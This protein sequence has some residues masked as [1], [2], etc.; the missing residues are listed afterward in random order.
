MFTSAA[1]ICESAARPAH[2]ALSQT[3]YSVEDDLRRSDLSALVGI[4]GIIYALYFVFTH[5][6]TGFNG[7]WDV[8]AAVLIG[9]TPPCIMLLS[10]T[11]VDLFRGFAIFV[12]SAFNRVNKTQ[13]EVIEVLTRCSALVRTEG[14]GALSRERNGIRYEL[15][16]DGLS[17]ILNDFSADEIRHNI[18]AKIHS[19]QAKMGTASHLFEN[20]SKACPAVGMIG[21]LIGLIT[22]LANLKDPASIGGGMAI[23][24]VTTLYGLMLG[25]I[26]YAPFGE[27]IAIES[28]KVLALDQ[29]ILE[30]ILLLKNKKSSLHLKD[31]VKTYG[32]NKPQAS[33]RDA[34]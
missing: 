10:H 14:I 4:G 17:L 24:M 23:A 7:F 19:K 1:F 32:H 5:P 2:R 8:T 30:G 33:E 27:K 11:L 21:T 9:V 16:R 26:I 6:H 28:E 20:M 18:Q 29:M 22:M 25:T 31:I 15:M 34:R 3:G 12:R 13:T